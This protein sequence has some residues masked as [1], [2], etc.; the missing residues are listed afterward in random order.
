[1]FNKKKE[2]DV[3]SDT[4]TN[5][6]NNTNKVQIGDKVKDVVTG[7]VGIVVSYTKHLTGCDT[8][9]LELGITPEGKMPLLSIDVT[10]AEVTQKGYMSKD[11]LPG[12]QNPYADTFEGKPVPAA[13]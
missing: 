11:K 10:R 2:V 13:G 8:I 7:A 12:F 3:V 1:M 4:F 5:T 6:D 9:T